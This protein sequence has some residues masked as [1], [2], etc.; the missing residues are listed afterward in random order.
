MAKLLTTGRGPDRDQFGAAD[1]PDAGRLFRVGGELRR[2]QC[3]SPARRNCGEASDRPDTGQ[4]MRSTYTCHDVRVSLMAAHSA[5]TA[6]M[7][8]GLGALVGGT[9][10]KR[11]GQYGVDADAR[12]WS[13]GC[14]PAL[15]AYRGSPS[16]ERQSVPRSFGQA[17]PVHARCAGSPA[18]RGTAPVAGKPGPLGRARHSLG[19]TVGI[20]TGR[21]STIRL[22]RKK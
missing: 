20:T 11:T 16:H 5:G 21:S 1:T 17:G 15:S 19:T 6:R 14:A 3:Y 8:D 4:R 2:A 9:V 12:R 18:C 7:R 22:D 10:L 13:Q